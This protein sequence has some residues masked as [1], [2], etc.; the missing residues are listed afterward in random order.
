MAAAFSFFFSFSSA[1]RRIRTHLQIYSDTGWIILQKAWMSFQHKVNHV[2][3]ILFFFLFS[4]LKALHLA[5]VPKW[6]FHFKHFPAPSI[7]YIDCNTTILWNA[8]SRLVIIKGKSTYFFLYS[9][10]FSMHF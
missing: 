10:I 9:S 4:F 3:E 8:R 2:K 1:L 6:I 7:T 5:S